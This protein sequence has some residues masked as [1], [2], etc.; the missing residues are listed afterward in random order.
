MS[1][2]VTFHCPNCDAG[3]L[4]NAEKGNF[5]CEFCLCEFS[6]EEL[7]GTSSAKQAEEQLEKNE[8]YSS[9]LHAYHCQN[10][11]AEVVCEENTSATF[12]YYC[13][14]PV[15]LVGEVSGELLPK[16]IIPFKFDKKGA[17][18]RFLEFAKKHKFTPDDYRDEKQLDMITGVY[19]PFWVTDADVSASYRTKATRSRSWRQG[20]YIYTETSHFDI[21]RAGD[22]HF[23]DVVSSALT[24]EDSAMLEGVMPYPQGAHID[25]D[26]A[27]LLGYFAKRRNADKEA[28]Y[29]SVREKMT[30]C[31]RT[32][33]RG[34]ISGYTTVSTGDC[35]LTI[36]KSDWSYT[37]MP[38]WTLTYTNKKG[39]KFLYAMNGYT[40]K[41][42]GELPISWVKLL[43][44]CG[45]I[46]AGVF[47]T[48]FL[49]MLGGIL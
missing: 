17:I 48:L 15:V 3:L 6:K 40:G 32:L 34:T 9:H 28:F 13:H 49:L 14:N 43:I 27:Y 37:L 26:M 42:Y 5:S 23:E 36:N 41:I 8:E 29:T 1:G 10:C 31:S 4:F 7:D 44:L 12:C 18:E 24:T 38:V 25:F 22:I 45:S 2:T 19:F 35:D 30:D 16:K 46:F 20:D 47:L 33:F 11:G 39:K 21:S